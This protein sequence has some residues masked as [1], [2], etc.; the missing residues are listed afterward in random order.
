MKIAIVTLFFYNN[1]GTA[2]QAFALQRTLERITGE[3]VEILPYMPDVRQYEYFKS[4]ELKKKYE[5]KKEIFSAFRREHLAVREPYIY[6]SRLLPR[7]F[8]VYIVGSDIVWGKEFSNL[9]PVYFL[10]FVPDDKKRV[11][12]GASMIVT[13]R[14]NTE[15]DEIYK[16][17]LPKMDR[18]SIRERSSKEVLQR[19]TDRQVMDVLDPTLLLKKED[20]ES[21]MVENDIMKGSPYLLSYFLTHDPAV[22]DYTILLAKKLGLRII[23]YFADYPDRVFPEGSECFAFAGPEE[24]LGY[25]KNAACIFTNSFHGTCF[26]TIFRKPFY[27]YTAKRALLTRVADMVERLGLQDRCFTDFRDIGRVTME[28][29]YTA[30][31]EKY[32]LEKKKSMEFLYEAVGVREHV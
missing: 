13:N 5:E 4:L 23:H 30:V 6:D 29:D 15:D 24:F 26:A 20:Y 7:D 3:K 1:F 11:S 27:T 9:D 2:L 28:C 19:F 32:K 12:Y 14:N 31:E 17:L 21:I 25:V 16:R 22:V 8:D 10:D 18:V